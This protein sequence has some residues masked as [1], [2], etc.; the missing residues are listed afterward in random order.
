MHPRHHDQ[1]PAGFLTHIVHNVRLN[2]PECLRGVRIE[3]VTMIELNRNVQHIV[4]VAF[5]T[6]QT[7]EDLLQGAIRNVLDKLANV[8]DE[9][10]RVAETFNEAG[11]LAQ[12]LREAELLL[13]IGMRLLEQVDASLKRGAQLGVADVRRSGQECECT[14]DDVHDVDDGHF[15]A[16]HNV[17]QF[18]ERALDG[19][20]DAFDHALDG[21][22]RSLHDFGD[23]SQD[24]ADDFLETGI[25]WCV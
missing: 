6:R 7:V 8:I 17:V 10:D 22:Q 13:A 20:Q 16:H 1:K 9:L 21:D 24:F 18:D 12:N 5:E 3:C 4:D 23:F 25:K 14:L 11:H 2:L 15:H 19:A